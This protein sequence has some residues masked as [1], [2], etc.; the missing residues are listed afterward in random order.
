MKLWGVAMVRN[1]ADIIEAF[2]RHNL[3]ILDGLLV[4]DHGS[5]DATPRILAALL[6]ERVPLVVMR[7]D[8]VGYLQA[9]IVTTAVRDAFARGRADA[10]FP[11]DADEFLRIGPRAELE[12]ALATLPA[13]H[14]GRVAW[15]TF[16]PPLDAGPADTLALLRAARRCDTLLPPAQRALSKV[17]L[18]GH[19]ARDASATLMMGN[20][21]VILGRDTRRSPPMPHVDLPP[22]LAEVCHVPVRSRRQFVTKITVKHLARLAAGRHYLPTSPMH[23]ALDAIRHGTR[24][25]RHQMLSAHR[26]LDKEAFEA[27]LA[28]PDT[29]EDRFLADIALRYT[30][31]LAEDAVPV[32]LDAVERLVRRVVEARAAARDRSPA[33][34]SRTPA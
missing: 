29:G 20:H 16:V 12:A 6:A 18:T 24:L 26:V 7:S 17:V 22:R 33:T 31:P 4:V 27:A 30:T 9:E 8:T 3:T 23:V 34:G 14:Y 5:G 11:L 21:D 1:E 10:V 32:V 25:T 15:P 28:L 13:G 2:V 19:F